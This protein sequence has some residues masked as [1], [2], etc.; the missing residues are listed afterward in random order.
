ML[1]QSDALCKNADMMRNALAQIVKYSRNDVIITDENY[2]VIIHNTEHNEHIRGLS[3][4]DIIEELLK[5]SIRIKLNNFKTSSS[6]RLHIKIL[7]PSRGKTGRQPFDIRFSK[8]KNSRNKTKGF[9]VI[10]QDFAPAKNSS[11]KHKELSDVVS[12]RIINPVKSNMKMLELILD[13]KFGYVSPELKTVLKEMLDTG[14]SINQAADS[15]IIKQSG[16]SFSNKKRHSIV[17]IIKDKCVSAMKI[18]ESR[19]QPAELILGADIPDVMIDEAEIA[20]VI[21]AIIMQASNKSREKTKII[22]K[23]YSDKENVYVSVS[24]SGYNEAEAILDN[25]FDEYTSCSNKIKQADALNEFLSCRKIIE[26]HGGLLSE[27]NSS[28]CNTVTFSLPACRD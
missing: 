22:L 15:L 9:I 12:D 24:N 23:V 5:D 26:A 7:P 8:I 10:L 27:K 14:R 2:N 18:L 20:K 13:N 3:L 6:N 28:C 16:R 17:K 1:F 4:F 21:Q 19:K 11:I 25:L